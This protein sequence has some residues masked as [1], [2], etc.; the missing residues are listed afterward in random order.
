MSRDFVMF[1]GTSNPA[2]AGGIAAELGVHPGSRTVT[3]FPDGE[4]EVRLDETVRGREVLLI[5]LTA[6]PVND[7]LI[8]L[9]TLADACRRSAA[10]RITAVVPYYGYARADRRR[11]R[12]EPITASLVAQLIQAAGIDHLIT[13]DLH[14]SQIEGFF[15]IPV[16]SLTAVPTLGEAVRSWLPPG[17]V[18]VSPDT[19][20]VAMAADYAHRL[21]GA[22]AIL[23]KRR[24]SGTETAV[25]RV[26]G[27]VRDRPCLIID[28]MISTGGTIARA[29]EALLRAGA[30]PEIVVAASHGLFVGAA[31]AALGH[32]AIREVFVT[33]SVATAAVDR[34]L[35]IVS[36]APLIAAAIRAILAGGSLS[37]LYHEVPR[38]RTGD[39]V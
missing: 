23:H 1:S 10:A 20:R 13:I 5:Q 18:I 35:R 30:R 28:D 19:G 15:Q 8:E 11:G 27:D 6:P 3:R 9:L 4:V 31:W 26:I 29:V 21:G 36:I 38:G 24:S 7:N 39:P 14:A 34:R 32:E 33:D 17:V 12:R 25:T 22:V 2:L 16:D 37:E